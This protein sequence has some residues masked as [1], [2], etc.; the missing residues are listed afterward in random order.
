MRQLKLLMLNHFAPTTLNQYYFSIFC[1]GTASTVLKKTTAQ[2]S[3]SACISYS[4][5]CFFSAELTAVVLLLKSD[6]TMTDPSFP[7]PSCQR[8]K[9]N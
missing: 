3:D 2:K 6:T 5:A 8:Q 4:R 7:D 9:L 1:R